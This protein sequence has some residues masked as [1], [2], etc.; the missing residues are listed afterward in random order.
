MTRITTIAIALAALM[1]LGACNTAA[2]LGQD[3]EQGGAAV[4][5]AARDAQS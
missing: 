4:E 5:D 2:G 1:G 3:I